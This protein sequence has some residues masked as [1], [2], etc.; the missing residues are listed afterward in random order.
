MELLNIYYEPTKIGKVVIGEYNNS[1]VY[2][3]F[4]GKEMMK[5]LTLFSRKNGFVIK[6]NKTKIVEEA[7]REINQYFN[8]ERREFTIPINLIGTDLQIK[9]WRAVASIPFGEVS[10][11]SEI[12]NKIGGK[13]YARVVGNAM[14]ANPVPIIIPCHR[15]IGKN[16]GLRGF[17]GG[18]R[19]KRYLLELESEN[20]IR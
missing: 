14:S 15:I 12:A 13:G 8:G 18:L 10:T 3:G 19:L 16:G 4:P 17:G 5:K 11:Y 7:F 1:V 6:L 2:I 9:I 20:I